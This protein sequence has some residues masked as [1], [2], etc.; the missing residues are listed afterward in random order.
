MSEAQ[1]HYGC[2]T[3]TYKFTSPAE[4]NIELGVLDNIQW[5]GQLS[6]VSYGIRIGI[7]VN[8]STVLKELLNYLPPGWESSASPIVDELYSLIMTETL[9][10]C[11]TH[12]YYQLY[13][14]QEKLTE[15][16]E[17]GEAL[18][19]LDSDLRLQIGIAVQDRLF[20]HAGV[21]GWQG[22]AIVIP[23]RSFSGKTTLIAALVKAGAIY[24]SDEYA[25]LD[26]NG[27]VHPY[28]RP[29][30]IRQDEDQG[31]RRCSVEELGGKAGIE[32]IPIGMVVH[33]QYRAGIQWSP[34]SISA[35]QAVLALLD[36]TIVA[37][38]RPEFALPILSRAVAD[39]VCVEGKRGEADETA[40][41][42]LN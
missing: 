31:V 8:E 38:L 33:T 24:Y 15:T 26:A 12:G 22:K 17:L 16:T 18:A 2:P 28:A 10:S 41:A 29:L 27:L 34:T 19:T 39:A 4:D 30:S 23:G 1:L 20:V 36:N 42:L 35:G 25:V 21:V 7:R 32:P 13:R 6:L 37:R 9:D 3:S 14:N 40:I 5:N 11:D